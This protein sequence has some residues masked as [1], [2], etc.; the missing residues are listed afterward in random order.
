M[1]CDASDINLESALDSSPSLND[2]PRRGPG[3]VVCLSNSEKL[4]IAMPQIIYVLE[5]WIACSLVLSQC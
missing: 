2:R 1:A 3:P 4:Y 5:T